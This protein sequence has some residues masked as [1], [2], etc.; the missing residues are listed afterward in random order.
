MLSGTET[1]LRINFIPGLRGFNLRLALIGFPGTRA[2]CL[3]TVS[4]LSV[5]HS[6][7]AYLTVWLVERS[8]AGL[9][10]IVFPLPPLPLC[11][12]VVGRC[13]SLACLQSSWLVLFASC[14]FIPLFQWLSSS[15]LLLLLLLFYIS[16]FDRLPLNV[17]RCDWCTCLCCLI[18]FCL[19]L[20]WGGGLWLG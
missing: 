6:T 7:W 1:N 17:F 12:L 11:I 5:L 20:H 13:Y 10:G 4:S 3:A 8:V 2:S 14:F 15:L 16:L 18:L 19:S 9:F